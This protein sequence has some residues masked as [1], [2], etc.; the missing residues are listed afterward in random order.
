MAVRLDPDFGWLLP[1][2]ESQDETRPVLEFI[3][4]PTH[5]QAVRVVARGG[6][7]STFVFA[8]SA[9]A[10]LALYRLHAPDLLARLARETDGPGAPRRQGRK[11][12]EVP[13][14]DFSRDL[15][16]Y[17]AERVRLLPGPACGWTDLGTPERLES[18]RDRRLGIR[19][20]AS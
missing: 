1:G 13:S 18:W 10:L 11:S 16:A 4:K 20:R 12:L 15:L 17:A 5:A 6:L 14:C 2:Q 7:C 9:E 3:E 19:V 8:A